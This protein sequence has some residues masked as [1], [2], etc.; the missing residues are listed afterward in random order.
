VDALVGTGAGKHFDPGRGRLMKEWAVVAGRRTPNGWNSLRKPIRSSSA[1]TTE[2]HTS[3]R[4]AYEDRPDV[5]T[6]PGQAISSNSGF[7]HWRFL[8]PPSRT[9][10]IRVLLV[11]L[12]KNG[13]GILKDRSL[14]RPGFLG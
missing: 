12:F 8:G 4:F 3:G 2:L 9:A 5:R 10:G 11:E 13:Y 14:A 1:A 7:S 6:L